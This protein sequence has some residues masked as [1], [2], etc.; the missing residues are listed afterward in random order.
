M[1][2]TWIC[3]SHTLFRIL[4]VEWS[5]GE[6]IRPCNASAN[7]AVLADCKA[8]TLKR[9]EAKRVHEINLIVNR[10]VLILE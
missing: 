2:K 3:L 10:P 8:G 4:I 6:P 7:K 1:N 9:N 5:T